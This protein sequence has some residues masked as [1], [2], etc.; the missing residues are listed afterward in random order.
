MNNAVVL[1]CSLVTNGFL[2]V[3]NS[4][5]CLSAKTNVTGALL[6][7]CQRMGNCRV[8]ETE[9]LPDEH[10]AIPVCA[11]CCTQACRHSDADHDGSEHLPA[12]PTGKDQLH[13]LHISIHL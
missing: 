10:L 11:K 13:V 8:A 3:N 9:G 7:H 1:H 6:H 5:L 4:A 12:I 2:I